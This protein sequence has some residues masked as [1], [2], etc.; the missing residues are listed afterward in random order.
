MSKNLV[1]E[2]INEAEVW[3]KALD[4]FAEANFL[5]SWAWKEFEESLGKKVWALRVLREQGGQETTKSLALALV[6]SEKAKRGNYLTVAAGP[7]MDWSAQAAPIIMKSLLSKLKVLA[8]SEQALFIRFRPQALNS[9]ALQKLVKKLG[10]LPAPMHLTADLTWQLDLGQPEEEILTAMRKNTRYEVRRAEKLGIRTMISQ[11]PA[12]VEAFYQVQLAVAERQ[13]FVPFA[14]DFLKQQFLA[15]AKNNQVALIHAYL[16]EELLASAFIIFYRQEAVYH[17]GI[18]T[19]ANAKLP[20]SYA[21]QWATI[22]EA[23]RRGQKIYNFWGV[24][25]AAQSKHRFAGVGLFKR[26]FGGS[27]VAYLPAQDY[28]LSI[29]Y[30]PS[31]A[32]ELLRKKVRGL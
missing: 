19:E 9:E 27:E 12:E 7:L 3:E 22:K 5:Q 11:N 4:Q 13:G 6:V 2:E 25:P 31:R 20:G 29:L 23:K 28:P 14:Y 18:S 24:A 1:I 30:W 21:C 10:C 32:F 8:Q 15:F 16:N 17:Y 26:G